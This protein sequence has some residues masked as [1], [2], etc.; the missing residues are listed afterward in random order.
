MSEPPHLTRAHRV[1]IGTVVAGAVIIAGIGF[2]GS[3]AA[4]RELAIKK[5]FGNF[6][7][8]FPIGIDAG[9]CV[10]LALDLLLT[11]IQIPF[12]LLR[13]TAWLLTAA[14]IAFNGAAA[15]PDPLGVGM[16]AVIPILFVV[17]VEAARHAIGK[18]AD[19]T[20]DKHME[21][22]RPARW[23][24]SPVPTFLLWRRMKLWELRSYEAVIKLEQERLVYQARL[25]SRFGR[26]WRRKAPAESLI[27]LRLTRY[28]IP[29]THT[30][31]AGLAAGVSEQHVPFTGS[32]SPLP[33]AG[34]SP[35]VDAA[36]AAH[37]DTA[38]A[39]TANSPSS[40]AVSGSGP[41]AT[42]Q[43]TRGRSVRD[44]DRDWASAFDTEPTPGQFALWLKDRYAV[45]TAAGGLL[46]DHHLQ[47]GKIT[48]F[49]D[50]PINSPDGQTHVTELRE[51]EDSRTRRTPVTARKENPGSGSA[52]ATKP[53][54]PQQAPPA[55]PEQA[56]AVR[57]G[58][59]IHTK[60]E[61]EA[62]PSR[63]AQ[64]PAAGVT[65][66]DRYYL[67]W[68]EYQAHHGT[69]PSPS[70][71]SSF[72]TTEGISGRGGKPVSSSTLRRYM[73]TFRVYTVW[74]EHGLRG[75]GVPSADAIAQACTAHGITGQYNKP[76]ARDYVAA[77]YEDF[78]RRRRALAQLH[79]DATA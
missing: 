64:R 44:A 78:E 41:R 49:S 66:V 30:T 59:R 58:P 4:V 2:A 39:T 75:T 35:Q 74:A 5:G 33:G 26:T 34:E 54:T 22:I 3:Y 55:A 52:Q 46:S 31:P 9:I 69:E 79:T 76:I 36:A 23:L 43:R 60:T 37:P 12:P 32:G 6:S 14:T 71:L 19:I 72:L 56:D 48:E 61:A 38:Q 40:S 25:R 70:E 18:I 47:H 20:A 13:Q 67:A 68:T 15:W 24:L 73:L 17:A 29:L 10:L 1:L 62:Q 51:R 57:R 8:V 77:Q 45:T 16:H 21:G 27:P 7:Y 42:A 65:R 50:Q 53:R 63:P 28:G 11:W